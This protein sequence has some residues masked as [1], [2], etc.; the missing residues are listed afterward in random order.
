MYVI[1]E[2]KAQSISGGIKIQGKQVRGNQRKM[3]YE[4]CA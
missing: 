3:K 1:S 4:K 2:G